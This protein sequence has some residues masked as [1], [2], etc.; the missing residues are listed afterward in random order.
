MIAFTHIQC[1]T[2]SPQIRPSFG[3][4]KDWISDQCLPW[5]G[6]QAPGLAQPSASRPQNLISASMGC[7]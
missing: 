2:K 1:K 5:S 4:I 7:R 3:E 6:E